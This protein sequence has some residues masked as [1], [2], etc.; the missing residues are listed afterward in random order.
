MKN[1]RPLAAFDSHPSC[2]EDGRVCS[3]RRFPRVGESRH[4][5]YLDSDLK[6]H[7]NFTTLRCGTRWLATNGAPWDSCAFFMTLRLNNVI[8]DRSETRTTSS[9]S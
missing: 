4:H 7:R 1:L 5:G 3:C 8:K 9:R 2:A 6:T